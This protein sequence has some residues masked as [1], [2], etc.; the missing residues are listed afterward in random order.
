MRAFAELRDQRCV[1]I[2]AHDQRS[3][4]WPIAIARE[5]RPSCDQKWTL[6]EQYH[7]GLSRFE[8]GMLQQAVAGH[9]VFPK[10][11]WKRCAFHGRRIKALANHDPAG[12]VD[13]REYAQAKPCSGGLADIL[14]DIFLIAIFDKSIGRIPG[15]PIIGRDVEFG[16]FIGVCIQST[17]DVLAG[18]LILDT[19]EAAHHNCCRT[20]IEHDQ[21]GDQYQT[22][23]RQCFL[24]ECH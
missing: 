1:Q 4:T 16:H 21:Q 9:K 13:I 20:D 11:L 18:I 3:T 7:A 12:R 24:A 8:V 2:S 6:G 15:C 22:H 17:L 14:I 23:D 10:A 19:R 5:N